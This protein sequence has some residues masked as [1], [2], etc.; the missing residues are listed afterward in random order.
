MPK[1]DTIRAAVLDAA[2]RHGMTAYAIAK[3]TN[4]AVSD[5]MLRLYFVGKSSLTS[6]KLSAVFAVFGLKVTESKKRAQQTGPR[7]G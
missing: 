4:G 6:E 3:A 5:D 1:H 2:A 7:G